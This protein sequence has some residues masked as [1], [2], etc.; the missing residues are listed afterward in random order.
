MGEVRAHHHIRVSPTMEGTPDPRGGH[1]HGPTSDGNG[2]PF[3]ASKVRRASRDS[4]EAIPP[5]VHESASE[6][7]A[8]APQLESSSADFDLVSGS[9]LVH[10]VSSRRSSS[11]KRKP[12]AGSIENGHQDDSHSSSRQSTD[13]NG[14]PSLRKMSGNQSPRSGSYTDLPG[15]RLSSGLMKARGFI[16]QRSRS[17]NCATTSDSEVRAYSSSTHNTVSK[18]INS[19]S[20]PIHRPHFDAQHGKFFAFSSIS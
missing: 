13:A 8:A 12:S 5:T 4:I 15:R 9:K 7:S 11:T 6:E 3:P 17:S 18:L 1:G 2:P 20:F 10:L 19:F 16:E 14:T